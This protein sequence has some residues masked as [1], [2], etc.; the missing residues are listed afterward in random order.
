MMVRGTLGR[1]GVTVKVGIVGPNGISLVG[2]SKRS[3]VGSQGEIL[4]GRMKG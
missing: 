3:N 2:E 4:R 1:I